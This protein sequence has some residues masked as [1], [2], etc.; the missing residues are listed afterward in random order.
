MT[1]PH[2]LP[3]VVLRQC[4]ALVRLTATQAFQVIGAFR[5]PDVSRVEFEGGPYESSPFRL[6]VWETGGGGMSGKGT[7]LAGEQHPHHN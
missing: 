6:S 1:V 2:Q 4:G 7:S 5:A 3:G